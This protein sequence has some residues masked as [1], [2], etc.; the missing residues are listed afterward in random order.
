[1]GGYN[2]LA[3]DA[4]LHQAVKTCLHNANNAGHKSIAFPMLGAGGF[5]YPPDLVIRTIEDEWTRL[6]GSNLAQVSI[7]AFPGDTSSVN[8]SSFTFND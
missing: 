8:V 1:M 2:G 6:N 7:I 3:S 5:G 4:A